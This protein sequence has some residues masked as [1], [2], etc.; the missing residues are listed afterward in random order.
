MSYDLQLHDLVCEDNSWIFATI[1]IKRF[2]KYSFP[3][4]YVFNVFFLNVYYIYG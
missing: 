1:F 3:N 2:L 4:F